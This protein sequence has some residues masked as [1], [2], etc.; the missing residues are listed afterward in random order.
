MQSRGRGKQSHTQH[1]V[2]EFP[3]LRETLL[4]RAIQSPSWE[5][6]P[7]LLTIRPSPQHGWQFQGT[8]VQR[9]RRCSLCWGCREAKDVRPTNKKKWPLCTEH[10]GEA[11]TPKRRMSEQ[12]G[13]LARQRHFQDFC[14]MDS[15]NLWP[16]FC[17]CHNPRPSTKP[18]G[19]YTT[20][21]AISNHSPTSS[22][23]KRKQKLWGK[24]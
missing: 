15:G 7:E 16:A 2:E 14:P 6:S 1:Q 4:E 9:S 12:K 20:V 19:P 21:A 23:M 8:T 18:P 11:S 3:W 22:E 5:N 10:K 13:G 24:I 17:H